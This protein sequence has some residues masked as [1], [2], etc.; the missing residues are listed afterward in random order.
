MRFFAMD[1]LSEVNVAIAASCSVP[2]AI[3]LQKSK[4]RLV[5]G[6]FDGFPWPK[7]GRLP[8]YSV[9]GPLECC[10]AA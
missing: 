9:P 4:G 3:A 6:K 10:N 1:G 8:P 2:S 5:R 7:K